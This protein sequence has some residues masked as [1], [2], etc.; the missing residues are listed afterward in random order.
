MVMLLGVLVAGAGC[1][2]DTGGG[3]LEVTAVW[4]AGGRWTG[5]AGTGQG[6]TVLTLSQDGTSLS[7]VW[8]WGAGDTRYCSGYRDGPVIYLWDTSPSGDAWT[9]I[10]SDDGSKMHGRANKTGG[11][12]YALQFSR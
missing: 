6:Y 9:L 2:D 4:D 10:L 12:T 5:T 8:T 1:E 7:G 11:G 3:R